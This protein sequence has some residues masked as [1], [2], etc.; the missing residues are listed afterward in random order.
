MHYK[1]DN[2]HKNEIFYA[3]NCINNHVI[4]S[5]VCMLSWLSVEMLVD[6]RFL[7][8]PEIVASA[9]VGV[10]YFWELQS[11]R[12]DTIWKIRDVDNQN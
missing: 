3:L 12:F 1:Y 8:W 4:I 10:H 2:M 6:R 11:L 5:I 9:M 7:W